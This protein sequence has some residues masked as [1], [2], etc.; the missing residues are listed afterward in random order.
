MSNEMYNRLSFRS[1]LR[2]RSKNPNTTEPVVTFKE[3]VQMPV[4]LP[5]QV[6]VKPH[7]N[8]RISCRSPKRVV[9]K[10]E[11]TY[12]IIT[13]TPSG[14][15][16]K[17]PENKKFSFV[18]YVEKKIPTPIQQDKTELIKLGRKKYTF[19]EALLIYENNQSYYLEQIEKGDDVIKGVKVLEKW[20]GKIPEP[21]P[22]LNEDVE[23]WIERCE[24][25]KKY[26]YSKYFNPKLL[27]YTDYYQ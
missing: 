21:K 12:K 27:T 16:V 10:V 18:K 17:V 5:V 6:P 7:M 3:P 19:N 24:W 20:F 22:L 9:P 1:P 15:S 8:N 23:E 11:D 26:H 4:Q 13:K 25:K 14:E 2:Q